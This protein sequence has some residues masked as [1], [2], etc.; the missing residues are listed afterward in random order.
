M[1]LSAPKTTIGLGLAQMTHVK[2][3][4]SRDS[5]V[6][7]GKVSLS[8]CV[9]GIKGS[10]LVSGL[11]II[12]PPYKESY[13]NGQVSSFHEGSVYMIPKEPFIRLPWP[14]TSITV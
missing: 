1:A 9:Y 6:S 11:G 10:G 2:T 5:D 14:T 13:S 3:Y 4:G 12:A 8:G 7:N